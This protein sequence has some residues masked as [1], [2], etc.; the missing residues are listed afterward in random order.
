RILIGDD[1]RL[2]QVIT[3][4]L[5]NAVKFTPEEGT[6][7]LDSRLVSMEDDNCC[8][9]ISV[10]DTGIGITDEQKAR[11]FRKF[12]QAESGTSRKFGGTGLGLSISKRIV[13]LMGGEMW[14]ESEFGKGSKFIFT[15]MLKRGEDEKTLLPEGVNWNNIR[16]FV[17]DDDPIVRE[18]FTSNSEAWGISC[19]V[20]ASGEEAVKKLEQDNDYDIHFI[21]WHLP[22]MDGCEVSQLI[23]EKSEDKLLIIIT[24]SIDR[25][26]IEEEARAAGV[27]KFLPKPLFPSMIVDI[28][29]ESI[30]FDNAIEQDI[31]IDYQD[32][33]VS[34]TI[35]LAEDVEINREIVLA[36][37]QP[38]GL[39]VDCAENGAKALEM[40]KEAPDKY[41]IIFM[42]VQMPEM[43]GHEAT[44]AIR[45]L[46][47]PRA[48]SIPIVA[49][50]A[51]VFR[52]DIEKCLEA[53]M[54]DHIGKPLDFNE[55]LGKLGTYLYKRGES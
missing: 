51:N 3:N 15:I 20:A 54:N 37:L 32:A 55:V 12:E 28:I 48:Q 34:N 2:A 31:H 23:R 50:T 25:C 36:L 45:A 53:G 22:G 11:L 40:F 4:L 5:S 35:L 29:N 8:L 6:I 38:T 7:R 44:R 33:F 26:M 21:D 9:Q 17:V 16:I 18:F 30:G 43:D 13:E 39:H 47:V 42:D 52:D 14:I 49:M 10:E 19:T 24:S 1:Q 41:D 27:A 46:D